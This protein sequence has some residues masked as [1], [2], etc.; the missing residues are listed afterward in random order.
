MS[1]C[2]RSGVDMAYCGVERDLF[3]DLW[4]EAAEVDLKFYDVLEVGGHVLDAVF[5]E[6]FHFEVVGADED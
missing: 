6:A 4:G 2:P 1:R 3:D 5:F